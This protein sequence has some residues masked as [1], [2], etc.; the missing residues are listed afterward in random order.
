MVV[1]CWSIISFVPFRRFDCADLWIHLEYDSNQGGFVSLSKWGFIYES[2]NPRHLP[3]QFQNS[4]ALGSSLKQTEV[5]VD[6][7]TRTVS[8]LSWGVNWREKET[9]ARRENL[10]C[11]ATHTSDRQ[12]A[13]VESSQFRRRRI[14]ANMA[15][16]ELWNNLSGISW[17]PRTWLVAWRYLSPGI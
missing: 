10:I 6:A 5:R 14:A 4:P 2:T 16:A 13:W 12:V 7:A 15:S 8:R 11:S 1:A 3:L 17:Q 9:G